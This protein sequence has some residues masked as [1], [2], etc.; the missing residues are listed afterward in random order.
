MSIASPLVVPS[1]MDPLYFARA[2]FMQAYSG[3][4]AASAYSDWE[5]FC[6]LDDPAGDVIYVAYTEPLRPPRI[7]NAERPESSVN[8]RVWTHGVRRFGDS[9]SIDIDDVRDDGN[10]AK[11]VLYMSA[12]ARMAEATAGLWPSIVA[13]TMVRGIGGVW[14]PDGQKIFDLH[15]FNPSIASYGTYRNYRANSVQGGGAA[16]PRTYGNILAQLKAGEAFKA[17]TGMD[18][19]IRYNAIIVPPGE[20]TSSRRQVQQVRLPA[21]EVF[22]QTL[23]TTNAGG[24]T[25]NEIAA[26][27]T[28]QV[29]ELANMPSGMWSLADLTSKE[30]MALAVKQRQPITWQQIGPVAMGSDGMIPISDEGMISELA[31]N[32]NTYR[33]GV[34]ARGDAYFRN[35]WRIF[36]ADG[37]ATPVTT[38]SVIS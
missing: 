25:D 1:S 32:A 19:P 35:W 5:R 38:L 36:L 12:M 11:K 15:P 22:G 34:K 31:F 3:Q 30:E 6:Y 21:A 26:R 7:W 16:Y 18:Y 2:R 9:M 8:G 13:E 10:P 24:D 20:A 29:Y 17:P 33:F 23:S 4:Y 27:Y 28:L 14:A 37:N